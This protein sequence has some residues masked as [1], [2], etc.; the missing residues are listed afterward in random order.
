MRLNIIHKKRSSKDTDYLY[1]LLNY[2]PALVRSKTWRTHRLI[3]DFDQYFTNSDEAFL[4]LCYE[5]IGAKWLHDY[6]AMI[7]RECDE[8]D[9]A[10]HENI[11]VSERYLLW[12]MVCSLQ[13]TIGV[14]KS[15]LTP[16]F[17]LRVGDKIYRLPVG[18]EAQLERSGQGQI[19]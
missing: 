10:S 18:F 9:T 4:L 13:N 12:V 16:G 14:S 17:V 3:S 11:P 7:M 1:F 6:N 8:E 15:I 5:S 2:V 19:Q